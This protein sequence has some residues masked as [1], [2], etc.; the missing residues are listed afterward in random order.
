VYLNPQDLYVTSRCAAS[1]CI[2]AAMPMLLSH[3][4]EKITVSF[5]NERQSSEFETIQVSHVYMAKDFSD[6]LYLIYDLAT[7]IISTSSCL[8]FLI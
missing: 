3:M 8:S 6:M 5:D 1:T 4:L 2:Q 7:T